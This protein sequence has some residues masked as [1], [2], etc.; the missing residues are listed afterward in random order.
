VLTRAG[1]KR[2]LDVPRIEAAIREA[3]AMSSGEIRVSVS[4][5]FWGNV[6]RVAAMAF[7]R[8]GMTRTKERNGVLLF[9]VPSRRRFVVLGDEGIHRK[10]GQ[11]LWDAVS[12][13]LSRHF[14]EGD[15]TGGLVEGIRTVGAQLSTHFPNQ[16]PRD[17]NEL[18]DTT[19]FGP[20]PKR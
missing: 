9:V 3:E 10:V 11:P 5:F 12:E 19:D 14:R 6:E 1:L 4:R 17:E 2:R 7:E 8:L 20:E 18:P 15:F 16:G 13:V